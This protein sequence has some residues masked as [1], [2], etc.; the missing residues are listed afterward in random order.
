MPPSLYR[1]Y[2]PSIN[3]SCK[4]FQISFCQSLETM[5]SPYQICVLSTHQ[6][7]L[8]YTVLNILK[9]ITQ[10]VRD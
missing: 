4:I 9:V 3:S 8:Y 6:L 2:F 7:K 10:C 1:L 5:C